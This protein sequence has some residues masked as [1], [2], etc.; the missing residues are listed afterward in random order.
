MAPVVS[1]GRSASAGQGE[2]PPCPG[3]WPWCLTQS[4]LSS[5]YPDRLSS[6]WESSQTTGRSSGAL[7]ERKIVK[8]A[9]TK[10]LVM[11]IMITSSKVSLYRLSKGSCT[12][13]YLHF[14]FVLA[15]NSIKGDRFDI[16]TQLIN[17]AIL[18]SK[19]GR[20]VVPSEIPIPMEQ[21]ELHVHITCS[22]YL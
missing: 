13:V 3:S 6:L 7:G 15:L 1:P 21:A 18:F 9:A 4:Q 22:C 8:E 14:F 11:R 2:S 19:Y 16:N 10:F 5:W 17:Y 12:C 20:Y